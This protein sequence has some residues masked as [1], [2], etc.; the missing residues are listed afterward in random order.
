MSQNN[1]TLVDQVNAIRERLRAASSSSNPS[2][3][4]NQVIDDLDL[5]NDIQFDKDLLAKTRIAA[6]V[7]SFRS[8][9]P[10]SDVK[11]RAEALFA[12]LT[13]AVKGPSAPAPPRAVGGEQM[14]GVR[15]KRRDFIF[16]T[17]SDAGKGGPL[18]I[19]DVQALSVEIEDAIFGRP[20]HDARF[21]SLAEALRNPGLDFP[22]KLLEGRISPERFATLEGEALMTE[23]QLRELD[24]MREFAI[25]SN[26]V[27]KPPLSTTSL[28]KCRKCGSNL[29]SFYQQQTRSAD[30]PMTNF[31]M[32]GN[33]GHE[34]RE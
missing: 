23:E 16:K 18:P 34:W 32:C 17:L 22:R 8:K 11:S 19:K 13:Q 25:A 24:Q 29:V 33:C 6:T 30:E 26:T 14:E 21:R 4:L 10:S 12:K 3:H 27:P 7:S 1:S 28:F 9:F 20:D 5:L 2:A 15:K 31:C